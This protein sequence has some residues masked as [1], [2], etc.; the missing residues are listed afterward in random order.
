MYDG[1]DTG[2]GRCVRVDSSIRYLED[3]LVDLRELRLVKEE[4][5]SE[6]GPKQN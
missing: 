6:R 1:L 4:W 3:A 2:S 5:P